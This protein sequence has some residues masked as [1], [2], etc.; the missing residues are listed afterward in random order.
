[1]PLAK[2]LSAYEDIRRHFDRAVQSK[3][4]IRINT[5]THGAAV[6]M[7]AR[8]YAMR[9]LEREASVLIYEPEDPR[10]GSSPYENLSI[11]VED[12]AVLIRHTE[13]ITIEELK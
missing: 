5:P 11:E 3:I 13:P 9:K 6:S 12:N 4:G 2:N 1:M 7:R 8:F 10:R